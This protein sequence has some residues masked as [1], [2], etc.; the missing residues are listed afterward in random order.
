MARSRT[1]VDVDA[2][3]RSDAYTG[4]L[5][6]SLIAMVTS[7][8]ILLMDFSQYK[9]MNPPKPNVAPKA[10]PAGGGGTPPEAPQAAAPEIILPVAAIE[11]PMPAPPVAAPAVPAPAMPAPLPPG[12]DGPSL[13]PQQPE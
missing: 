13:P 3:P 4:L 8:V 2:R 11:V 9:D 1:T 12:V 10:A 5:I 6:L 7:C